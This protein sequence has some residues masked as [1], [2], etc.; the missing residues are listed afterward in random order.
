MTRVAASGAART[1]ASFRLDGR[2]VV[3]TGASAG[4]GSWLASGLA[5]AGAQLV[6]TARS[7][8][9]LARLSS[10]LPE[11]IAVPGDV[12]DDD[13]RARIVTKTL[14]RYGRI[15]GL[16]NNAGR[17]NVTTAFRE[18][19]MAFREMLELNLLA[20]YDLAR[21]C[22]LAMRETGGGSIVNI[23]SMSAIVATASTG[24]P[25][26]GYCAAKA[27]L[28]HVT[29]E[30]A[31]QWGRHNIRVNAV[32]PGMFPTA[33]IDHVEDPPEFFR[34]RLLL[35]RAGT[36]AEIV[37]TVQYLLSDAAGYITGQQIPVDG[38]RTVT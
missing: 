36:P 6:L 1:S 26:A 5:A 20:P 4:I 19:A 32:A 28:A 31:G 13:H 27:G 22:A 9:E 17:L 18:D 8:D 2:V 34:Q 25:S 7:F 29:R 10:C 16:V 21:R 23:T 33:M 11:A 3:V 24:V 38:G 14:E 15:D 12:T 30:L 37:A 35:A